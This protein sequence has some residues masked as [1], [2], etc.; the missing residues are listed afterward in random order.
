MSVP[1]GAFAQFEGSTLQ[2]LA[3]VASPDGRHVVERHLSGPVTTVA[4]ATALGES[5]GRDMLTDGADRILA[6]IRVPSLTR[7]AL[8]ESA[9]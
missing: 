4:A 2:L 1:V 5:L 3:I 6:A 7:A 9:S 8:E